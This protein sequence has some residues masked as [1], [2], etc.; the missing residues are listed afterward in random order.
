[1][2]EY[3]KLYKPIRAATNQLKERIISQHS[4]F[5]GEK[6]WY[7]TGSAFHM[8]YHSLGK[9]NLRNVVNARHGIQE[10]K[11]TCVDCGGKFYRLVGN[12]KLHCMT[13]NCRKPVCSVCRK[14]VS[15]D[16]RQDFRHFYIH[17]GI[18]PG[19]CPLFEDFDSI[20]FMHPCSN[21]KPCTSTEPTVVHLNDYANYNLSDNLSTIP[22]IKCEEVIEK[23]PSLIEVWIWGKRWKIPLWSYWFGSKQRGKS[24]VLSRKRVQIL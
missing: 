24:E 14:D 7:L 10:L 4:P 11:E 19:M 1:M 20:P 5:H 15:A 16:P 17:S 12:N 23:N 3:N 8:Y 18:L 6:N 2:K 13:I 21:S 22:C 9:C